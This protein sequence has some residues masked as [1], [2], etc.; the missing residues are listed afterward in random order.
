VG[1]SWGVVGKPERHTTAA[2]AMPAKG[3][4][5]LA[6]RHGPA[7]VANDWRIG[8]GCPREPLARGLDA[9]ELKTESMEKSLFGIGLQVSEACKVQK[10][11]MR[12]S[13]G[14]PLTSVAVGDVLTHVDGRSTSTPGL[15]IREDMILGEGEGTLVHLVFRSAAKGHTFEVTARR[16]VH[17]R[18]WTETS[19]AYRLREALAGDAELCADAKLVPALDDVRRL[20]ADSAGNAADLMSAPGIRATLGI[21]LGATQARAL[22]IADMAPTGPAALSRRIEKGDT[23]VAVDDVTATAD[24]IPSLLEGSGAVGSRAKLKLLRNGK[25]FE[26]ELFRAIEKR[27]AAADQIVAKISEQQ[28]RASQSASAGDAASA[29]AGKML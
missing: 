7:G 19:R 29:F 20:V 24:N 27:F 14:Q 5:A 25:H 4:A 1:G 18:S 2:M 11:N 23:I 22:Q 9:V 10:T 3:L 8:P 28:D 21:V 15:R 13:T 16:H 6:A 26:L 12:D 17:V